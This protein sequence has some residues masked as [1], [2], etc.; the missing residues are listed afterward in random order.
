MYREIDLVKKYSTLFFNS[1]LARTDPA[2][3][4]RVESR[5]F[6]S[7]ERREDTIPTPKEGVKGTLGNWMSPADLQ[8]A[9]DERFPGCMKGWLPVERFG[10]AQSALPLRF[11]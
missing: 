5:T 6:I 3:V 8:K 4:A 1:Y 9:L 10:F 11:P 7:T 2:D